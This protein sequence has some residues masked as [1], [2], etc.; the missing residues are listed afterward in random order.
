MTKRTLLTVVLLTMA[1][2]AWAQEKKQADTLECPVVGFSFG[3]LMP[4]SGSASEG[5]L[6][7]NMGDLYK[8]PY[9]NFGIEGDYKFASGWMITLN[10]DLWFGASSNNLQRRD[11]RYP[12]I[13]M[14]GGYTLSWSGVDGN[15]WAHNRSLAARL[16]V[17]KILRVIPGNPNSGILL[18]MGGGWVMQKTIFTQDMNDSPVPQLMGDY[19]KLH[20]HLRNGVMLT[21]SLGF[22]Y[23]ANYLTYVNFKVEFTLSECMMWSSRKYQIDNLM[24]L[25]GKDQNRYFD[26]VYGLKLT[27]MFPL[28]GKT[29]YDYYYF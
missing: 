15:V 7:G 14:P 1:V 5:A 18:G 3:A 16:G 22:C 12:H 9:L 20:D 23:M 19:A 24:G 11:E 6:N 21:Q 13:F 26:L 4:G 29:T 8:G 25:N 10:G 17:A 27:W 28:M 2:G